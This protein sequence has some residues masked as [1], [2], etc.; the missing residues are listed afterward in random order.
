MSRHGGDEAKQLARFGRTGLWSH[1]HTAKPVL[2]ETG[3][4]EHPE[5]ERLRIVEP[6]HVVVVLDVVLVQ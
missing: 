5:K 6:E 1:P 3:R 4:L 2:V